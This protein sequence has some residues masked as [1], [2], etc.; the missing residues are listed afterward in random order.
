MSEIAFELHDVEALRL[1]R[2]FH[3]IDDP[4]KRR[5]VIA[6]AEALARGA[7][8]KVERPEKDL[9]KFDA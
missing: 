3:Q 4:Q 1:M 6:L 8:I 7:A 5:L 9:P 2:A